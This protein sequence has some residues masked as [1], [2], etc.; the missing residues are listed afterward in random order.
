MRWMPYLVNL[1]DGAY[2]IAGLVPKGH[3]R[4]RT[5][6]ERTYTNFVEASNGVVVGNVATTR[7]LSTNQG[8]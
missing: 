8:I 1:K 7:L 6:D 3:E 2:R 5:A 4:L